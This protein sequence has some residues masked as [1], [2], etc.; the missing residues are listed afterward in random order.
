LLNPG[1]DLFEHGTSY[2]V[3]SREVRKQ[4][5]MGIAERAAR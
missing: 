4:W 3:L 2:V 5:W 1:A